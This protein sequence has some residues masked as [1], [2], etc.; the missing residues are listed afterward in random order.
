MLVL[1]L[2]YNQ[3]KTYRQIAK[4]ATICPRDIKIIVDEKAKEAELSQT[5]SLSSQ[6]FSLFLQGK[7]PLNVAITL[8]LKEPEVLEFYRQYLSLQQQHDLYKGL[9]KN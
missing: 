1:D 6:A 8:N 4:E 5:T 9:W 2:Y 7:T 3:G